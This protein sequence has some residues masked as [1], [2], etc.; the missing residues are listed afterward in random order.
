MTRPI[1]VGLLCGLLVPIACGDEASGDATDIISPALD[2]SG[3][4]S[5]TD[6]VDD[7]PGTPAPDGASVDDASVT[8]ATDD[9]AEVTG[10]DAPGP[11][12]DV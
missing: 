5:A 6:A 10:P 3:D 1:L 2:G 4:S 9:V 12:A 11:T 8:D 7:V